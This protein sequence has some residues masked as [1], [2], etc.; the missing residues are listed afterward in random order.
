MKKYAV[1]ILLLG[2][3]GATF[4]HA[5]TIRVTVTNRGAFVREGEV[6]ALRWSELKKKLPSLDP[7]SAIVLD[8]SGKDSL[9][10]Q[11]TER[12]LLFQADFKPKEAR[13]FIIKNAPAN[14]RHIESL[15]DGRFVLPREDYAWENDRI[16]FRM[17]GPAMAKDVNN[18]IDVWTK[19]V[20]YLIV[21]KWYKE[22]EGSPLG[23]DTYHIDRGEGADFFSVGKS[24]GAGSCAIWKHGK[25]FQPGVF[26][27][28][29]TL[30]NGPLRVSFE[31]SYDSLDVQGTVYEQVMCITLDAGQNLNKIEVTYF[32]PVKNVGMEFACGLVKRKN[33][34]I[35]RNK[36]E[37]W[38]SLWGPTN[39]DTVNGFL[40]TAVV[41][42]PSAYRA[43][44]EDNDQYLVVGKTR[45]GQMATYY[46]G[47]GW[48]RSGDFASM[49]DWNR[50]VEGFAQRVRSPLKIRMIVKK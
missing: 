34:N 35:F 49:E 1:V 3:F 32:G 37:C 4:C 47:A 21:Q 42:P 50:Y 20:R 45:G 5:Q 43:M 27:S 6:V 23:K 36:Q 44:A 22:S 17:Y 25:V 31:L 39:D 15:V 40:G 8:E 2:A 18:G 13:S 24:L 16:A 10:L 41:L 12:D 48:T 33:T 30:T 7:Q 11:N 26:S 28:L 46:A 9:V 14:R 19:R 29:R 38:I